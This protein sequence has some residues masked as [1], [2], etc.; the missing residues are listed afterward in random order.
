MHCGN[1]KIERTDNRIRYDDWERQA[2]FKAERRGSERGRR[3]LEC[4][5]YIRLVYWLR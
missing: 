2:R 4:G 1:R 3:K 5:Q